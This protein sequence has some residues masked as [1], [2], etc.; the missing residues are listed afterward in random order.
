MAIEWAYVAYQK[1][2]Y[3][4]FSKHDS[5]LVKAL[6]ETVATTNSIQPRHA[7]DFLTKH[8]YFLK[9]RGCEKNCDSENIAECDE[10]I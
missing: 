5:V 7:N 3:G 4:S 1:N 2:N 6:L 9:I 8:K 10:T